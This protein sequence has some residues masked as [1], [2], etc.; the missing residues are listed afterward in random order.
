MLFRSP[1]RVEFGYS[2]DRQTVVS[3]GEGIVSGDSAAINWDSTYALN[4]DTVWFASRGYN[5]EY[6]G[7]WNFAPESSRVVNRTDVTVTTSM[8]EGELTFDG[9]T[10]QVPFDV[11]IFVS[12]EN[13]FPYSVG[14][15]E[16]QLENPTSDRWRFENWSDSGDRFHNMV[17]TG[18][19]VSAGNNAITAN[20]VRQ[21]YLQTISDA[22]VAGPE[23]GFYD[24]GYRVVSTGQQ[25]IINEPYRDR[26]FCIGWAAV[27]P[28]LQAEVAE[29]IFNISTKTT[30]HWFYRREFSL[31]VYNDQ[32]QT[33]G[34][35]PGWYE[36]GTELVVSVNQ[37]ITEETARQEC[38]GYTAFGA[39]SDGSTNS[40]GVFVLSAPT[41]VHWIW[42]D[43]YFVEFTTNYGT[44]SPDPGWYDSGS[45]LTI[46]AVS[47]RED[48]WTRYSFVSWTG[49]GAGS[50][51]YQGDE[52]AHQA[53]VNSP[54][55]QTARWDI[56]HRLAV[57]AEN[58]SLVDDPSGWYL[59]G[60]TVGIE[61]DPPAVVTGERWVIEWQGDAPARTIL[62]DP[63]NAFKVF[64]T[65]SEGAT[66]LVRFYRQYLLTVVNPN[67]EAVVVPAPGYS[68]HYGGEPVEGNAQFATD[69]FT[70]E[71]YFATGSLASGSEPYFS[72]VIL[73]PTMISWQ[74][75]E[76]GA[77]PVQFWNMPSELAAGT[78]A[79]VSSGALSDGTL[80]VAYFDA[81]TNSIMLMTGDGANWSGGVI[82]TDIPGVEGLHLL[83]DRDDRA[84]VAYYN[85]VDHNLYFVMP[86]DAP[87]G[88]SGMQVIPVDDLGDVGRSPSVPQGLFGEVYVA[89]L[90]SGLGRVKLATIAGDTIT[91]DIV[92]HDGTAA[93]YTS[94]A[95]RPNDGAPVIAFYDAADRSLVCAFR[96]NGVWTVEE[97]DAEGIVGLFCKVAASPSGQI[98]IAYQ[99]ITVVNRPVVKVAHRDF[100]TWE[101]F[102]VDD[103]ISGFYLDMVLDAAARPHIISSNGWQLRYTRSTGEGWESLTIPNPYDL[104][105]GIAMVML[106]EGKPGVFFTS[107]GKLGYMDALASELVNVG[108]T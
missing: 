35:L 71:G 60:S 85:S 98:Y 79:N 42:Q 4:D 5:G 62:R 108:E 39:I 95:I 101:T 28:G 86:V 66:Q 82:A 78:N 87:V 81:G 3:V 12:W 13:P 20:Y 8:G 56:W 36:E 94:L 23:D 99:D 90:D 64:V 106:P 63:Q 84:H 69:H 48:E 103:A 50:V 43:Q 51:T 105:E 88:G 30:L 49:T 72:F 92:P 57:V 96:D 31:L 1:T 45:V 11:N 27:G 44:T 46:D 26:R 97:V 16:F 68:W 52:T 59:E 24:V 14:A 67:T 9:V 34:S 32:G 47:P 6:W 40:S 15:A 77:P 102:Q 89:Y 38:R 93:L 73:E 17:F 76:R 22:P 75:T 37:H 18:E 104:G 58:G 29:A 19:S 25:L 53:T 100:Y 80:A 10:R 107:D 61:A 33:S 91:Y 41:E 70:V 74:W 21:Y 54:I 2:Y 65:L 55:T 83:I 7:V